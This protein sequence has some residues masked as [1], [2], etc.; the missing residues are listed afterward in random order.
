VIVVAPG[1]KLYSDLEYLIKWLGYDAEHNSWIPAGNLDSKLLDR[2]HVDPGSVKLPDLGE[3][4][5]VGLNVTNASTDSEKSP[6]TKTG[7]SA[8]HCERCNRTFKGPQVLSIKQ[9]LNACD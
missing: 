2:I 7:S 5:E 8:L 1:P 4:I 6:E 3:E 9:V